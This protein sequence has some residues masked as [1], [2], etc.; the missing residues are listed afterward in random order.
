MIDTFTAVMQAQSMVIAGRHADAA[1]Y[2]D[3]LLT[4]LAPSDHPRLRELAMDANA[5]LGRIDL[6]AV[7][8]ERILD[9]IPSPAAPLLMRVSA[10]LGMMGR[11]ERTVAPL[12]RL[13]E[14]HPHDPQ[15]RTTLA[16]ALLTL[17]RVGEAIE[18]L[19]KASDLVPN[20][21]VIM[22][23]L[24][25]AL[26]RAGNNAA[27]IALRRAEVALY[28]QHNATLAPQYAEALANLASCALYDDAPGLSP[29]EHAR[30]V[31]ADHRA[32][33]RA[34]A[35]A[36][37]ANPLPP[38]APSAST[39]APAP[40]LHSSGRLRVGIISPDLRRHSVAYF[41]RA[42]FSPA[43]LAEHAIDLFIYDVR[44][45]AHALA[46]DAMN[47]A[48]RASASAAGA[49]WRDAFTLDDR[50]LAS[51]IRDDHLDIAIDLAGLTR[52]NRLAA[53]AHRPAPLAVTY[54]GYPATTGCPFIGLRIVDALTDPIENPRAD[55]HASERLIRIAAPF[56]CYTPP[57]AP[58][59]P[60]PRP[61]SAHA[62]VSAAAP[63]RLGS[64]N[65]I[66]KLNARTAGLW[67]AAISAVANSTLTL[68][69]QALA[70]EP[71]RQHALS[72][73]S[74]AGIDPARVTILPPAPDTRSHLASYEHLDIALDTFPF[75][76]A[77]TTCE[78]M[79]MGVPV[80]SI[81]G[82]SHAARVGLSLLSGVGLAELC[83]PGESAFA[84]TVAALAA[85]RPRLASLHADLRARMLASA[86]C[87]GPA[88]ARR[89]Y[90][91]LRTSA[92]EPR[93]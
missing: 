39:P 18:H 89:F 70:D 44:E 65:N 3:S 16:A 53:L 57:D 30:A 72:L 62:P 93:A 12:A 23:M 64:F 81:A 5:S 74:A 73:L 92:R 13:V 90:A 15:F 38:A 58:D 71:S 79:L 69:A 36:A 85:D 47:T 4:Q 19:R 51:L 9:L 86:L 32:F 2:I 60:P 56:I 63:I 82:R 87:D 26:H 20:H 54:L 1:A 78:A 14:K 66:S 45:P 7:H 41:A 35:T 43:A 77:T 68:K 6:A 25:G 11:S 34:L 27:S 48:L 46:P 84:S 75:N 31:L 55:D 49:T 80:V 59:L 28:E 91:A 50:A 21:P 8:A 42:L 17:G 61:P 67:A 37:L 83:A 88:F 40:T 33:G 24:A 52:G 29:D 22:P 76:G 10:V